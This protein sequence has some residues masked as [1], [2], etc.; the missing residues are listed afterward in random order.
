MEEVDRSKLILGDTIRA[1]KVVW[2]GSF[3]RIFFDA[4]GH[5]AEYGVDLFLG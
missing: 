2:L 3:R 5:I 4:T 1:A